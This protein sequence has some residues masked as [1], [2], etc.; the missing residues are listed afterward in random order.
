MRTFIALIVCY[1]GL[2]III[3]SVIENRLQTSSL[4]SVKQRIKNAL[5]FSVLGLVVFLLGCAMWPADKENDIPRYYIGRVLKS[6][7]ANKLYVHIKRRLDVNDLSLIIAK[8]K[9]DSCK[10]KHFEVAFFLP[11]KGYD[12]RPYAYCYNAE[13]EDLWTQIV[14]KISNQ[15]PYNLKISE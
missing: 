5:S 1:V 15:S 14:K 13:D 12:D 11:G 10:L 4:S 6:R 7:T 3:A 8:I 9:H 2:I